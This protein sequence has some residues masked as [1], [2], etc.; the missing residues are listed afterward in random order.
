MD[1]VAH[2][3]FHHLLSM[4]PDSRDTKAFKAKAYEAQELYL[5][6]HGHEFLGLA[7]KAY[8]HRHEQE[9]PVSC[10]S[11]RCID[12]CGAGHLPPLT[13]ACAGAMCTPWSSFGSHDGLSSQHTE[14]FQLCMADLVASDFDVITIENS[15]NM[16]VSLLMNK[17]GVS[18]YHC[19]W[20]FV[21]PEDIGWPSQ[22]RRLW[23]TAIR[24]E[25]LLWTGPTDPDGVAAEFK[26]MFGCSACVDGSV[27]L[28][29]TDEVRQEE[30][31]IRADLRNKQRK[32]P[33]TLA[34]RKSPVRIARA[35]C[36]RQPETEPAG[37]LAGEET[38]D[39]LPP[40]QS[41]C[42]QRAKFI[43]TND[44]TW[45]SV[46]TC[47]CDISQNPDQRRRMSAS[48]PTLMSSTCLWEAKRDV[49]VT[50]TELDISQGYPLHSGWSADCYG[51]CVRLPASCFAS[52]TAS[53]RKHSELL[54]NGMHLAVV[55]AWHLFLFAHLQ[56]KDRAMPHC[57]RPLQVSTVKDNEE[58][59]NSEEQTEKPWKLQRLSTKSFDSGIEP[60]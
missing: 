51:R 57:S 11:T 24:R 56:R 25:S 47:F 53:R 9:C 6:E 60:V 41:A 31:V 30:S 14:S 17:F 4:R 12:L 29:G 43:S 28:L 18:R 33:Q 45:H 50:N 19:L 48:I 2:K 49:F 16:P 54:G 35:T 22:R 21:G 42:L 32:S 44:P 26:N 8:C 40:G 59:D 38:A 39:L 52:N 10:T 1:R 20:H 46:T 27:F 3:K 5:R 15:P 55:G 58:D 36:Q 13:F 23:F 7:A 37:L 34:Q